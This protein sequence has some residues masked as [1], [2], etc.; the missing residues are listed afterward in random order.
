[1]PTKDR[2]II[3]NRPDYNG[4]KNVLWLTNQSILDKW[5]TDEYYNGIFKGHM[6]FITAGKREKCEKLPQRKNYIFVGDNGKKYIIYSDYSAKEI[7]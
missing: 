5:E 1:M 6:Q 4:Y 3:V 7:E 2:E